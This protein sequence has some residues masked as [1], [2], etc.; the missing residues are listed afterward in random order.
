MKINED[1]LPGEVYSTNEQKTNKIWIDGKPIYRRVF[2]GETPEAFS[3]ILVRNL[4][5]GTLVSFRGVI[6]DSAGYTSDLNWI[7]LAVASSGVSEYRQIYFNN[8]N[9]SFIQ[10]KAEK[11]TYRI[12][13]EYTKN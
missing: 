11:M 9:I 3:G 10:Y 6:S 4:G 5:V 1:F 12:I 7:H 13:M 8:D 2:I